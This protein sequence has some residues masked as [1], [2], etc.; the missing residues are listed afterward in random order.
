MQKLKPI[1]I[2]LVLVLTMSACSLLPATPP[3]VIPPD[4]PTVEPGDPEPPEDDPS[5]GSG[6]AQATLILRAGSGYAGSS[7]ALRQ[8]QGTRRATRA[9][10]TPRPPSPCEGQRSGRVKA[11]V[12]QVGR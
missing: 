3:D 2:I 1:L 7:Q 12:R 10:G 8:A 4:D 11:R 9:Q 5:A 6:H